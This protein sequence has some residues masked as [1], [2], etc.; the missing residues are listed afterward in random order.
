MQQMDE[1]RAHI[2][3]S[4]RG[5]RIQF[6]SDCTGADAAFQAAT[7]WAPSA[8]TIPINAFGSEAPGAHGPM[9]F[10]MLNH[11]PQILFEDVLLRSCSGFCLIAG[12]RVPAPVVDLYSAGTMCTD[13]SSLNTANPKKHLGFPTCA[14]S[15]ILFRSM[16]RQLAVFSYRLICSALSLVSYMKLHYK[17]LEPF[18]PAQANPTQSKH[19]QMQME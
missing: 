5:K 2:F 15:L 17:T 18:G 12:K 9:L 16:K 13:F 14:I 4:M 19:T 8:C 10:Q 6:G 11:A 3:Q 1:A 7:L